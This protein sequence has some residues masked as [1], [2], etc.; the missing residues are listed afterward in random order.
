MQET[1]ESSCIRL[2][3][4]QKHPHIIDLSLPSGT[5]WACCNVGAKNPEW[6]GGYL[7]PLYFLVEVIEGNPEKDP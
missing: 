3:L 6:L 4:Q 5:K 2:I 7:Q 1:T